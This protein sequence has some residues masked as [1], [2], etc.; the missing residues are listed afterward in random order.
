MNINQFVCK[1]GAWLVGYKT[2]TYLAGNNY[3]VN[4]KMN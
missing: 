3:Q 2:I 1:D 4:L